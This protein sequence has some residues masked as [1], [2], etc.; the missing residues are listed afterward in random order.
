[1]PAV[2]RGENIYVVLNAR[3][4]TAKAVPGWGRRFRGRFGCR[5]EICG[6]GIFIGVPVSICIKEIIP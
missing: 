5:T 1:M 2:M 3:K 4:E 6:A